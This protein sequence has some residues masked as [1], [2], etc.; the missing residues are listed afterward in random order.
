MPD[1]TEDPLA[2][3]PESDRAPLLEAGLDLERLR[4]HMARVHSEAPEDN[5]VRGTIAAPEAHE[6]ES[7]PP[8]GSQ[9]YG[10][11]ERR[12]LEALEAGQVALVVLAGGM[13]TRM[14]GVVKALVEALPGHTFLD[15]RLNE[16]ESN[17]R[18]YGKPP[19]LWIMTSHA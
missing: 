17:T 6:I 12:G 4:Q 7:L 9:E 3:L 8:R 5:F 15:L 14:G 10:M 11:L 13:A 16:A 19:P 2:S 1:V 18:R